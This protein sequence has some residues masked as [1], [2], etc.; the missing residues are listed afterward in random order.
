MIGWDSYEFA[1]VAERRNRGIGEY[2]Y[3]K[4]SK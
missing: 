4:D 3:A 2:V 1:N